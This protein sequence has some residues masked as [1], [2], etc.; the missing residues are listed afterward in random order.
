MITT[1]SIAAAEDLLAIRYTPA[2]RAQMLDNLEGQIASAVARRA[3]VLDNAMPTASRFDPRLA[4]TPVPPPQTKPVYS[5]VAAACPAEDADIAFA[6]LTHLS[7]WMASGALTSRRLTEI[8]LARIA[9]FN[10]H[11]FCY[12]TVMS[13]TALAEADAADALLASG[14]LLGPL[15]GIPYGLKDLFDTK[16]VVTGWGAEPFQDRIP[17][18]DAA[19]V[20]RLRAAGAVLLGKTTVGALAYNDIWYGG[21]TRNPWNL[22]EGSS[23]SSAGS[24]S[25]TAAG[26]CGF[27]IGTETL[28]SITS[29]S[30]RCGTTGLRPTFGRVSRA[31][32][33]ALC[34][35]LDKV[36]PICRG[37]EDTAIVLAALNGFDPADRGSLGASFN[38]DA[39]ASF[40]GLRIGFL[41]EAFGEGATE[42]DHAAL[43]AARS[44]GVDVVEVAL[45]DLPYEALMNILYAEAAAAFEPL[46]LSDLDDTLTWQDDGAWPNTFRKAR[47]L[48][49][50]DHVQLD[51]L[52]YQVMLA[53]DALFADVDLLIGPF[54]TGPMLVASNFTGHPCLH[55]RAG[56]LELATRG[57]ASLGAG[58][59]TTGEPGADGP[60]F[61]VP[62]GI[63]LWCRLFDEGRLVNFGI[64]LERALGVASARPPL[65]A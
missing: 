20:H 34:W 55:L 60:L 41:P 11:L 46:T 25:A 28:G 38:F 36:G 42:V 50:V 59:L 5:S 37:V 45:P 2:E 54:M 18:E 47:F 58:K 43:A 44:L 65:P 17:T 27:S 19:I 3:V 13:E 35:S 12:A 29:P 14:T 39:T 22:E 1:E 21:R 61:K 16:G 63:S 62:Q 4:T 40:E 24:A 32:A 30:Q 26:L 7:A 56:F 64:A 31:G 9:A 6:P 15:H 48:S 53:L 51:R 33:M 57:A 23:G 8:Y 49:A 10:P 52:R